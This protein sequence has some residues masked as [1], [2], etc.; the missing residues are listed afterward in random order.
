MENILYT[1][2]SRVDITPEE[3]T[4]LAGYGNDA[5]RKCN[6]I[7]DRVFGTCIALRDGQGETVILCTVDLLN[8]VKH[9]VV[10]G[11]RRAIHQATG[12][13]ED[14]ISV[15]VTHTHAG[16][17]M[18]SWEEPMTNRFL[19][20]YCKQ[21]AKAAKEALEDLKPSEIRIGQ[22]IVPQMTFVRHY[23]G[24]D[25][26]IFGP[27]FGKWDRET[28]ARADISDDQLQVMRFVR[29]GGR[30][31]VL[32]NWQSH[33]TITGGMK[34]ENGRYVPAYRMSADW[35]GA[36]RNHVEGC[37]GCHC[38]Y[39]QGACGNLVPGS[40]IEEEMLVERNHILYGR[41]M[42]ENVLDCLNE[43]MRSVKAGPIRTVQY[44]FEG[45]VNH[46]DDHRVEDAK[47]VQKGFYEITDLAERR[48]KLNRYG[49]NSVLHA[50][51]VV[52]RS[53]L[54]KTQEME[55][56][57]I[58]IGDISFATTP[59][60]MFNSNGR[61]VKDNTPYEMTFMCAY[62]N[63]SH[64]YIPDEKAF[65]YDCYELNSCRF[66]KGTGEEIAKTHIKLLNQLKSDSADSN[67]TP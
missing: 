17:S 56:I 14:H 65:G 6:Q 11:A 5:Y 60:E 45:Q 27:N 54:G 48:A 64:S 37:T 1:G 41:K 63:G 3:Y 62:S 9:T 55:L 49:F 31:I 57:A 58:G 29:E 33:A 7:L 61:Y 22:R 34:D 2:F 42:A 51:A 10:E 53:R 19:T 21:M 50:N 47:T 28:K 15:S 23:I 66:L 44:Q 59:I 30:D 20:R 24:R 40:L 12:V 38:A 13:A 32:V 35:P 18:Y 25:G 67:V 26:T 8:A 52:N 4:T 43:D 46:A 16:P 39:F 36:M